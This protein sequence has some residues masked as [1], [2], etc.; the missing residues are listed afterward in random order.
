LG[1]NFAKKPASWWLRCRVRKIQHGGRRETI[2]HIVLIIVIILASCFAAWCVLLIFRLIGLAD[3]FVD[4][5]AAVIRMAAGER[6]VLSRMRFAE[7]GQRLDL[8]GVL[9]LAGGD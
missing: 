5:G 4:L 6:L 7:A 9:H 1:V 8:D 2:I 3:P